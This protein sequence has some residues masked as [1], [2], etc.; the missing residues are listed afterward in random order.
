MPSGSR[1]SRTPR[2]PRTLRIAV[3]LDADDPHGARLVVTGD[4][5]IL[6]TPTLAESVAD[7]LAHGRQRLVLDLGG[8]S[9]CD[10]RGLAALLDARER[11]SSEGGTVTIV[12]ASDLLRRAITVTGLDEALPVVAE[13]VAIDRNS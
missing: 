9:F 8:A 3:R 12:G 4:L 11:A 2:G 5:D 6:S 13:V 10:A 1:R 7:Q